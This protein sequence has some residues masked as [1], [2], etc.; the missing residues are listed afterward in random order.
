MSNFFYIRNVSFEIFFLN[1]H[2]H[3]VLRF[4][5]ANKIH[6]FHIYEIFTKFEFLKPKIRNQPNYKLLEIHLH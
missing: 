1:L 2:K 3:I 4:F 6:S 5:I